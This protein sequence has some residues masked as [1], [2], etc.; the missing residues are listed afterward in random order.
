MAVERWVIVLQLFG[1]AIIE[2]VITAAT[3]GTAFP[4]AGVLAVF[5]YGLLVRFALRRLL[6]ERWPFFVS[7]A[8][9]PYF[10]IFMAL[11]GVTSVQLFAHWIPAA[12]ATASL[13]YDALVAAAIIELADRRLSV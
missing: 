2:K 8:S 3:L 4:W 10:V 7:K 11:L 12:Q 9:V 6:A 13:S 1:C 5:L